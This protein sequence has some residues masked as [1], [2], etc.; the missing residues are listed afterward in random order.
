MLK[1]G[2]LGLISN[3]DKTGYEIMTVFRDSLNHFWTAQTSQIYRE[4]QTMERSGWITQTHVSQTG[5]PDKN[6]FSI[7]PAGHDELLRWLRD[8]NLPSGYRNPFLMK[9][10]FMGE[11]PVEENIAFFKAFREAAIFP[12]EGKQVSADAD[13][14]R[15]AVDHPEKAIYWKLTI[16]FGRMYEKMQRAWCDYCIRELEGLREGL[17]EGSKGSMAQELL[18][19]RRNGNESDPA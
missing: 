10:F 14:Y 12:D 5:R 7:T 2:I 6:V 17:G 18:P 4:L 1:H 15:Q 13:W 8:N 16:E 3:G 9:T 11:L 19:Q